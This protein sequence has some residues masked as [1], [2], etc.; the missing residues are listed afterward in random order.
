MT[1]HPARRVPFDVLYDNLVVE[2]ERGNVGRKIE[3]LTGLHLFTYTQPCVYDKRW[4]EWNML[5]RGLILH[6]ESRTVVATPFP[7]FFNYGEMD[8]SAPLDMHFE[9]HEKVDGSLII[10]YWWDNRWRFATKGSFNSTQ[11]Q[12]A[13]K[14]AHA[15]LNMEV[16]DKGWT[17]LF[18]AIY[19]E[20]K[21]VVR[22]AEQGLVLL[23]AYND[24]GYEIPVQSLVETEA[25]ALGCRAAERL[26]RTTLNEL[27]E[28]ARTLPATHEGWV[29]RFQ[30]GHRIKIKGAEYLR[31]HRMLSDMTPLGIWDMLR[32]G[33]N[34]MEYREQLP[35][36]FLEDFDNILLLLFRA[37]DRIIYDTSEWL[38][39]LLWS[40]AEKKP[41]VPDKEV[42]LQLHKAPEHIRRFV[43][44]FR[45]S[46]GKP[47]KDPRTREA[48][49]RAIR[50]TNNRLEG[51]V[52]STSTQRILDD[53]Q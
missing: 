22:Y 10:A 30:N 17:Y 5:A 4:N 41:T 9:A 27:A 11:A 34:M 31:L 53:I 26:P 47:L 50:P 8:H 37:R 36:E 35:E 15:N 19:P 49:Y 51:Y 6:P 52:P 32:N 3:A 46:G 33:D 20:N 13:D 7:K 43:F 28:R 2:C 12:W 16:L 38:K 23:S 29:L 48:I 25:E 45:K 24:H 1:P 21:I 18:E 14:W 40:P 42:G 44:P 39:S